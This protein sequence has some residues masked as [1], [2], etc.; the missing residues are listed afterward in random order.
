[1]HER[2]RRRRNQSK[3]NQKKAATPEDWWAQAGR[4]GR[5]T[6]IKAYY[7]EF[8]GDMVLTARH[9][10]ACTNCA[11]SGKIASQGSI[12]GAQSV[13]CGVCHGTRFTRDIRA[14]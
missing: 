4:A 14:R 6:W 13:A 2:N 8:S 1:M 3:Q 7:A 10:T 11:G 9:V 5:T 12:G